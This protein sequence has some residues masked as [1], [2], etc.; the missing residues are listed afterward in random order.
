MILEK[1]ELFFKDFDTQ[2]FVKVK[3]TFGVENERRV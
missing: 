2:S 3:K 1:K